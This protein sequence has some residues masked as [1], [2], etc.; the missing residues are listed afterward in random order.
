[1]NGFSRRMGQVFSERR[2]VFAPCCSPNPM[3]AD[4]LK[5]CDVSSAS[6]NDFRAE[7]HFNSPLLN[8]EPK[9]T[10]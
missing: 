10:N 4:M 9:L 8:F 6:P 2:S 3:Y 7:N 5:I 1:M